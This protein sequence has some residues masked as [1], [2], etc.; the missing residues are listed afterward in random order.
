MSRCTP[1]IAGSPPNRPRCAEWPRWWRAALNLALTDDLSGSQA[2]VLTRLQEGPSSASALAGAETVSHQAVSAILAVLE[3]RG[4]I[5]RSLDPA[6][7]RRQL[8]SLTDAG[9]AQAEHTTPARE[10]FGNYTLR[11]SPWK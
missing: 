5:Q 11:E 6:H 7:G 1:S 9:V 2:S 8:V 3:T 4:Y 10:E